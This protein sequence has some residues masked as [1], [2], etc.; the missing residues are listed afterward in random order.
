MESATGFTVCRGSCFPQWR[1]N[2]PVLLHLLLIRDLHC[3]VG[4][5]LCNLWPRCPSVST[6]QR[7]SLESIFVAHASTTWT[8]EKVFCTGAA[9]S[10]SVQGKDIAWSKDFEKILR[11]E[12]ISKQIPVHMSKHTVANIPH[13][14]SAIFFRMNKK[15]ILRLRNSLHWRRWRLTSYKPAGFNLS[16]LFLFVSQD[17]L[18]V[19]YSILLFY[20]SAKQTKKVLKLHNDKIFLSHLQKFDEFR[21][22]IF[23][24]SGYQEQIVSGSNKITEALKFPWALTLACT[25]RWGAR[26]KGRLLMISTTN[27]SHIGSP[28]TMDLQI[29]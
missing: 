27:G 10:V 3:R 15:K 8:R 24:Y 4:L 16:Y 21:A 18:L 23:W 2:I 9:Y 28:E 17:S 14:A 6:N 12:A 25:D 20:T 13:M 11:V 1:S 5:G 29:T 19:F 7:L 22:Q 26:A